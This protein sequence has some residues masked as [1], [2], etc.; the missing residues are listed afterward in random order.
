MKS[1]VESAAIPATSLLSVYEAEPF[2][3]VDAYNVTTQFDVSL[4]QHI[5]AFYNSWVF[6]PERLL[7]HLLLKHPSDADAVARLA[8]GESEAFAAW[9][10][11]ARREDEILL[12]DV[13]GAT[14]SWLAVEAIDQGTRVWFGSAVVPRRDQ[15]GNPKPPSLVFTLLTGFHRLYSRCLLTAGA[16]QLRQSQ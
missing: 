12:C 10:V 1:Q 2:G 15:D 7:I 8:A 6:R 13:S 3:F 4:K 9:R 5:E 14:R 16:H 11:E